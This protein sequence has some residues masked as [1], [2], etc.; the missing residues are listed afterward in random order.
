MYIKV[1]YSNVEVASASKNQYVYN[2][3]VSDPTTTNSSPQLHI[4]AHEH[5]TLIKLLSKA[6]SNPECWHFS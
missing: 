3:P 6:A 2:K 5:K 4:I 1:L